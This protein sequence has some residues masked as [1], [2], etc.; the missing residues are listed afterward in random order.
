MKYK[1]TAYGW[2]GRR[3]ETI[4]IFPVAWTAG[5]WCIVSRDN[6]L[7]LGDWGYEH[8]LVMYPLTIGAKGKTLHDVGEFITE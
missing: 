6:P 3:G 4:D 1:F 7:W 2:I 8:K 5:S